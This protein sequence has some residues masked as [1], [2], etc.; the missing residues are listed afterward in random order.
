MENVI[1]FTVT[2]ASVKDI[3]IL[4]LKLERGNVCSFFLKARL[5]R[6]L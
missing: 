6:V 1:P 5:F 4:C 3:I 2:S